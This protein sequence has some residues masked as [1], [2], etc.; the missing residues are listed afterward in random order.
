[1]NTATSGTGV[2]PY[3]VFVAVATVAALLL[4]TTQVRRHRLP[5][6]LIVW[7]ILAGHVYDGLITSIDSPIMAIDLRVDRILLV[8]FAALMFLRVMLLERTS[9][10]LR[11]VPVWLRVGLLYMVGLALVNAIHVTRGLPVRDV[12]IN[13]TVEGTFFL[14]L[15]AVIPVLS[16]DA[17]RVI[18]RSLIAICV[19]STAIGVAQFVGDPNFFRY[20]VGRP[21]FGRLCNNEAS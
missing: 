18:T 12:V 14:L 15:F 9:V 20:G 10:S 7:W 21:A 6:F 4:C 3:L 13:L 1:M 19:V 11:A 5:V 2:L 16:Q 17:I 8:A